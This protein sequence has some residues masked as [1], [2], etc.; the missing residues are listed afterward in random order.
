ML[1]FQSAWCFPDSSSASAIVRAISAGGTSSLEHASSS[2]WDPCNNNR[3]LHGRISHADAGCLIAIWAILSAF[4]VMV[5][6]PDLNRL[7]KQL[8]PG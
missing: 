7:V 5:A 2:V 3:C 6:T 8:C 4:W 1:L